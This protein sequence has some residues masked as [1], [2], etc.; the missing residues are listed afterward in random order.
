MAQMPFITHDEPAAVIPP[1]TAAFHVP[2]LAIAFSRPDRAATCR[3]MPCAAFTRWEGRLAAPSAPP[4]ATRTAV[5]RVVRPQRLRAGARAATLLG[6]PHGGQGSL[7]QRA[8]VGAGAIT[9][10]ANRQASARGPHQHCAA[11]TAC[12]GAETSAPLLAGTTLPSSK[13][14]VPSRWPW[15]SRWLG[16][17]RHRCSQVPS[18]DQAQKRRQ[19]VAGEPDTRGTSS[20]VQ[21][22][23]STTRMP[24]RVWRAL[25]RLNPFRLRGFP[26]V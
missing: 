4:R 24:L 14:G 25:C 7:R 11:L 16:S 13:A 21:P 17:A 8:V 22:V 19:P 1:P 5:V 26:N 20:H 6:A 12:R 2:A 9:V 15:V 23:C 3:L 18:W 10:Q